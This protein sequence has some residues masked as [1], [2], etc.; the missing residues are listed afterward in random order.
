[1]RLFFFQ[2]KLSLILNNIIKDT[3][4]VSVRSDSWFELWTRIGDK[5]RNTTVNL[6]V[7][8]DRWKHFS[9]QLKTVISA[10]KD[11][12]NQKEKPNQGTSTCK[13]M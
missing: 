8:D 1:M 12:Q 10:I 4:R 7:E 11:C 5:K 13:F 9:R 2:I 6:C 3:L